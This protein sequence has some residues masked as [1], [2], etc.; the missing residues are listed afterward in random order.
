MLYSKQNN[1][2][3]LYIFLAVSSLVLFLVQGSVIPF[4]AG[5]KNMPYADL[6]LCFVC[7]M[8]CFADFKTSAVFAVCL[9]FLA[10]LFVFYPTSLSPLVYLTGVCLVFWLYSYFTNISVVTAAVCSIPAFFVKSA[11]EC[12]CSFFAGAGTQQLT[13]M[14]YRSFVYASLINFAAVL[15]IAFVTKPFLKKLRFN[16]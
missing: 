7:I 14:L 6:L 1:K 15:I 12:V 8:P 11:A 16:K 3:S 4:I 5:E 13:A 10:D 2:K 9:G